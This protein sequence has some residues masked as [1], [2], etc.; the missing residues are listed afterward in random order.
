MRASVSGILVLFG[1]AVASTAPAA[2]L[3]EEQ[4]IFTT[5]CALCHQENPAARGSPNERAPTVSQLQQFQPEAVITA[6]TTGK[7]QAQGSVLTQ[8]QRRAVAE[9]ATGKKVGAASTQVANQ[10]RQST[11]MRDPGR[12]TQLEWI[13]RWPRRQP[14]SGCE[15][16]GH[17]RCRSA[18]PEAQMGLWL[19]QRRRRAHAANAGRRPAVRR[20]R[21]RRSLRARSED[22]LH[23]LDLPGA[24][25][26]TH[27]AL[28]GALPGGER[29]AG[30]AVYLRRRRA[31]AYAVDAQTGKQIWTTQ[32]EIRTPRPASPAVP[33]CTTAACTCRL[34]G[35]GEEGR[36]ATDRYECC[37]FR[38]SVTALDANTGKLLWK[39]YT[40]DEPKPRGKN[41]DGVQLV[42]RR[43]A[44][45]GRRRRSMSTRPGL[46]RHRQ[47]LR[48]SAAEDDER[49]HRLRSE[50][51]RRALVQA[52]APCAD[53][54]WPMGCEA[55]NPDNPACPGDAWPG[56]RLLG[57]ADAAFT[58][59]PVH[60][61]TS[62][63]PQ[64]SATALCARSG[65]QRRVV[66]IR[67]FGNG[68]GLGG[69][70]GTPTRWQNCLLRHRGLLT[71]TRRAA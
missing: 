30:T 17:H 41:K 71:P 52:A 12:R 4:L 42:A 66:W 56:L 49:G 58:R 32:V 50:D 57:L 39:T 68:S 13:R 8:T 29:Q 26:R 70:W 51:R 2:Q 31:N 10:C 6:L 35:L 7:M 65:P 16:R 67:S 33:S 18:A 61:T 60:A 23:L 21:K 53:N 11:P 15:I 25:R 62:C 55:K 43:A 46:C 69:Q 40:I 3:P 38:G 48:R 1:L 28:G 59:S 36:G 34:Q 27:R 47:R 37:T 20:Q 24:G 14:F 64:K 54:V 19:C 22:R 63:C 9:F 44:A 45:S 5:Q